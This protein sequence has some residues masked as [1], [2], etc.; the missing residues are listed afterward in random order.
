MWLNKLTNY[1]GVKALFCG[2][3]LFDYH[4]CMLVQRDFGH[5]DPSPFTTPATLGPYEHDSAGILLGRYGERG[6]SDGLKPPSAGFW[7]NSEMRS[8]ICGTYQ[9]NS[10]SSHIYHL[11]VGKSHHAAKSY[12]LPCLEFC[13]VLS[14]AVFLGMNVIFQGMK[15][16]CE[17]CGFNN[18]YSMN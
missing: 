1:K 5:C 2:T 12:L 7:I 14:G 13:G 4:V 16:I 15:A 3:V 10:L 17:K 8:M 11:I 9:M 6:L 18:N